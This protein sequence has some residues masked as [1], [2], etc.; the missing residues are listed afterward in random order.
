[1]ATHPAVARLVERQM[2]NWELTRAQRP[3]EPE[4][5]KRPEVED[6]VCLSR[7]A[8]IDTGDLTAELGRRLGWPVFGREILESMAGD[9]FVRRQIYATM[10]ER[11]LGWTEEVIRSLLRHEL[12]RNDYF[13]RLCET[14]V[15]LARQ[16]SSIFVGRGADLVL[17]AGRG[18]RVRVVASRAGR[19]QAYAEAHGVA[20]GS[21]EKTL[22]RIERERGE[23]FRRHFQRQ[24]QDP[25][26]HDLTINL[27]RFTVPQAVELILEAR[28]LRAAE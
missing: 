5:P 15:S 11:D 27:D 4:A 23:F 18:L 16:G 1:M 3:A 14:L 17:P 28:R 26:R 20:E 6:F 22:E 13:H 2:R 25:T 12:G 21:A 8:G 19:V 9:D 7:L 10:D 24:A